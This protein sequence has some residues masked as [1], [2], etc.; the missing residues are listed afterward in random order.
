M[1][2][3]GT[4]HFKNWLLGELNRNFKNRE[5]AYLAVR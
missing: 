2:N 5:K 1:N 3:L 4:I